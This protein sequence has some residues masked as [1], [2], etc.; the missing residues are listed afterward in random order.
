MATNKRPTQDPD[1][2]IPMN[3]RAPRW[4]SEALDEW[5]GEMNETSRWPKM[6]RPDLIRGVLEWAVK[7]KPDWEKGL[8]G[9]RPGLPDVAATGG[10]ARK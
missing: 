4:L 5:T 7:T 3:F 6:K 9:L 2:L 1:E 10:K 8:A